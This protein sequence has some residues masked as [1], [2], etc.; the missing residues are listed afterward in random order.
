MPNMIEKGSIDFTLVAFITTVIRNTYK[1][2]K[3]YINQFTFQ[4]IN[5]AV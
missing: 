5:G 2:I 3:T 1:L 4:L